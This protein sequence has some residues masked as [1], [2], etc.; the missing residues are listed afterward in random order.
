MN[1]QTTICG[2]KFQQ[3]LSSQDVSSGRDLLCARVSIYESIDSADHSSPCLQVRQHIGHKRTFFYLE[4]LILK[5]NA[6]VQCINIKDVHGVSQFHFGLH[7][8]VA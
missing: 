6:D 1:C 8:A 5:F 3:E 4:Q 7:P 2:L